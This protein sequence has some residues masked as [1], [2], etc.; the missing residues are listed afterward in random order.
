MN[1]VTV[2][3]LA[4]ALNQYF[5]AMGPIGSA[6]REALEQKQTGDYEA[7][8]VAAA[9]R[10]NVALVELAS[11]SGSIGGF[12]NHFREHQ[13]AKVGDT[14]IATSQGAARF[15][16]QNRKAAITGDLTAQTL[17]AY[18]KWLTELAEVAKESLDDLRWATQPKWKVKT[19][20]EK[21]RQRKVD[22]TFYRE[23]SRVEELQWAASASVAAPDLQSFFETIKARMKGYSATLKAIREHNAK[24]QADEPYSGSYAEK[25]TFGQLPDPDYDGLETVRINGRQD[26]LKLIEKQHKGK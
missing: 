23:Q 21:E 12:R 13:W 10:Y 1:I 15:R 25:V 24:L 2:K 3:D 18:R 11:A 8:L 17:P 5:T 19:D 7:V 20:A 6:L 22:E 16:L 9:N 26:A 14:I 4:A